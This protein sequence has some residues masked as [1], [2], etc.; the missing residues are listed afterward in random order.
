[1]YVLSL[2]ASVA[3][4]EPGV[5]LPPRSAGVA[6]VLDFA[7]DRPAASFGAPLL[8][9]FAPLAVPGES[10]AVSASCS[11]LGRCVAPMFSIAQPWPPARLADGLFIH[12]AA[13]EGNR[14]SQLR[15]LVVKSHNQLWQ[16]PDL[17]AAS[18]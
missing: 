3:G 8:H 15:L 1:M 6:V 10:R 11:A 14:H 12:A 4:V 9:R 7:I 18:R 5:G 16:P 2:E 17:N 13:T